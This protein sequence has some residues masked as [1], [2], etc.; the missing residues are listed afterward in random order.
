MSK[1]RAAKAE[2][3]DTIIKAL[4]IAK[5]VAFVNFSGLTVKDE[6]ALRRRCREEDIK[7]FVA[8]KTLIQRAFQQQGIET[9]DPRELAGGVALVLGTADEIS[10]AK[11]INEF[12]GAHEG[13]KFVG[14][15]IPE[16]SGWKYL[17]G[18]EVGVLAKLPG[19]SELIAILIGTMANPMRGLVG[20]LSGNTK[21]FLRALKAIEE[22]RA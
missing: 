16:S 13:L 17:S 15:L 1:S 19:R 18:A 21:S 12:A 4:E 9:I 11:V 2:T 14:G 7:Y 8:K 5:G 20:V 3:I 6:T 22:S 10:A